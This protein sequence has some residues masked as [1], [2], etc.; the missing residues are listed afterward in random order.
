MYSGMDALG[1]GWP[2][3]ELT[4]AKFCKT[5]SSAILATENLYEIRT[6]LAVAR[7]FQG[8]P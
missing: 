2:A 8:F 6:P 4:Q 1:A 5:A 7:F 3:G